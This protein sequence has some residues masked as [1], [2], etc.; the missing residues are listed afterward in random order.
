M[1]A[2]KAIEH[3]LRC[4]EPKDRWGTATYKPDSQTV[5]N[6]AMLKAILGRDQE[7]LGCST[8]IK[9]LLTRGDE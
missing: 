2:P 8:W 4:A 6:L 9:K 1:N 5:A 7:C 3:I